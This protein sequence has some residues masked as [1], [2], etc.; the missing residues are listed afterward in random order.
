MA[1]ATSTNNASRCV[2][3]AKSLSTKRQLPKAL[4]EASTK[5]QNSLLHTQIALALNHLSLKHLKLKA[6]VYH[7]S[8]QIQH[9]TNDNELISK[10]ARIE[11]TF[12]VSKEVDETKKFKALQESTQVVINS[13]HKALKGKILDAL[14]LELYLLERDLKR[15]FVRTLCAVTEVFLLSNNITCNTNN[16]AATLIKEYH[17]T[18]LKHLQLTL[19]EFYNSYKAVHLLAILS[20]T[21][22]DPLCATCW[23]ACKRMQSAADTSP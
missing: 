4:A 17:G 15:H 18:I 8:K 20:P 11:F 12:H 1:T 5:C 10:S 22:M 23:C 16:V 14:K 6:K 19:T 2:P 7:E 9:L 13:M 3:T 21:S